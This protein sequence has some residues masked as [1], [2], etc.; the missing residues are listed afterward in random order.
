[1]KA[2]NPLI[3]LFY[4]F[5]LLC[6]PLVPPFL[7]I[8]SGFP[9]FI[10]NWVKTAMSKKLVFW[11]LILGPHNVNF[12]EWNLVYPFSLSQNLNLAFF[13]GHEIFSNFFKEP[14]SNKILSYCRTSGLKVCENINWYILHAPFINRN[15]ASF[16]CVK[17]LH[18][19]ERIYQEISI[20]IFFPLDFL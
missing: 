11:L 9:S 2:E 12:Y 19:F 5:F 17:L 6:F 16:Y 3:S 18:A 15:F 8:F 4:L 1:M 10:S 14:K 20:V 13:H 7:L